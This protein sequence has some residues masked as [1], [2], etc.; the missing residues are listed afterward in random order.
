[1]CMPHITETYRANRA[2]MELWHKGVYE[3]WG[4][5]GGSIPYGAI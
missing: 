4:G 3:E 1:M 5:G 2:R